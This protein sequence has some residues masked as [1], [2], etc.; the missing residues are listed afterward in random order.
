MTEPTPFTFLDG[1][2]GRF[3]ACL[4]PPASAP[5]AIPATDLI[6]AGGLDLA[7]ETLRARYPDGE[8]R[9]LLSLWSR[10]YFYK[11]IPPVMLGAL[12]TGRTLPLDLAGTGVKHDADGLPAA[13]VLPHEGT[14][15]PDPVPA[16]A[17]LGPLARDHLEP[18]IEALAAQAR[19]SARVLWGNAA[20]YLHWVVEQLAADHETFGPASPA[21]IEADALIHSRTWP[22]GWTNAL[23]EPMRHTDCPGGQQRHRKVCCLLYRVPGR[24]LCS[25]CP[26]TLRQPK[27][28]H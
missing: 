22:D 23:D 16:Q 12:L 21:I 6:A 14:A 11:L 7:L 24:D 19:V 20:G 2:A 26:L 25:Y 15:A 1:P 17:V 10:Y 8:A 4:V 27:A 5:G 18:L 13:I 28:K 3:G 9:A